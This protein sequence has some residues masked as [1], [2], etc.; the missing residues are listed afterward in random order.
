MTFQYYPADIKSN[1]PIGFVPLSEFIRATKSP[2]NNIIDVFKRISEAEKLNDLKLKAE[3]KQNYLYYFTPCVIVNEYRRYSNISKFTGLA[4]LDFDHIN[5]AGDFKEFLFNEYNFIISAW[6]SPSKK[7]IKALVSIPIVN[8]IEEFKE[9]FFGLA[10]EMFIYNGFDGTGENCVLPLFQS[11]DPELL[12]R[13]NYSIWDIKGI[14][15]NSIPDIPINK[16]Q[17]INT[18][19]KH[20]EAVIKI[21]NTAYDKIQTNGHP[22]SRAIAFAVGGYVSGGYIDEDE[23]IQYVY[24]KIENNSYLK[25]GIK[26]YK[27]TALTMIQKGQFSPIYFDW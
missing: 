18:S 1:K 4:V 24:Y 23:A 25:K 9:Y 26:G 11:Y 6:L 17:I 10:S 20:K 7:G 13:D 27:K 3:L 14:K 12:H 8:T 22:Q 19:D 21:I 2:K 16:P 15:E 5:N